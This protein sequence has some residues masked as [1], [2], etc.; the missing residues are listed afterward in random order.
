M[1]RLLGIYFVQAFHPKLIQQEKKNNLP[2]TNMMLVAHALHFN[3][4]VPHLIQYVISLSNFVIP[5]LHSFSSFLTLW[6]SHKA[7]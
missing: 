1:S 2:N 4:T 7:T 5:Q 6:G 3:N